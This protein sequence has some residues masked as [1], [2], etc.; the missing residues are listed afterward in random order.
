M[1]NLWIIFFYSHTIR[2]FRALIQALLSEMVADGRLLHSMATQQWEQE[3]LSTETVTL[4][5]QKGEGPW[6][7]CG[8]IFTPQISYLNAL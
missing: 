2:M 3:G 8:F 4:Q 5:N 7:S 1:M 6:K